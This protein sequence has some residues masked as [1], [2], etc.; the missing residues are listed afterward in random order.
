MRLSR[1]IPVL[2]L[3]VLLGTLAAQAAF[4]SQ[5][6]EWLNRAR[7]YVARAQAARNSADRDEN[8]EKA[9]SYYKRVID[10]KRYRDSVQALQAFYGTAEIYRTAQRGE[11]HNPRGA[12]DA[13]N[14]LINQ[15]DKSPDVLLQTFEQEEIPRITQIVK[16]AK[17]HRELVAAELDKQNSG[18]TLYKVMD[19]F[20][21]VT[22]RIRWFSYWFAIILVTLIVKLA[23]TPLTKAQ[24]KSMKEI[25]R[26]APLIKEIQAKH[27]G[28][29]RTINEK[30]MALYKEH[31][32][33]MFASCLP[34]LIQ[35]PILWLLY[36]MIRDYEFQFARGTFFW[37]GSGLSH[38]ASVHVPFGTGGTVWVTAAN[39]AEPD[40]IL[41]VLYVVSMYISTK[42]SA[43]DPSQA[44]QQ[45]MMS[46]LLPVMF[47]FIFAGFPSAFLLYWLVYNVIQTAQQ[48]FILRGAPQVAVAPAA[49][50]PA[51]PE[52][53][54]DGAQP[55]RRVRRRR[56][57]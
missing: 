44:E 8:F 24:F 46:I 35:M 25:Q 55:T 7:R 12:Y 23:I 13:Y 21:G 39:L 40:L 28:D 26:V 9:I 19:F 6:D 27:R 3:V 20:V 4:G 45:K 36:Y 14:R 38:L 17:T 33:N 15:Y 2:L 47:A 50:P 16:Q 34:I 51:E 37:I 10:D 49:A 42:L 1:L 41:V 22:G 32:I 52:K 48:Y 29:Q 57:R 5:A 30:T 54:E 53:P 18:H 56:R 11:Y 43:V 31:N